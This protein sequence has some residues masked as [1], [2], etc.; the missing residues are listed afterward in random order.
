MEIDLLKNYPKSKR[1]LSN[2]V[3]KKSEEIVSIAR[4]FGEEFFDGHRNY[5]YG[6]YLPWNGSIMFN[7]AVNDTVKMAVGSSGTI[8]VYSDRSQNRFQ[9]FLIG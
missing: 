3:S 8:G 4:Q 5:G 7:M 6:G 1:D 9:G 2:R